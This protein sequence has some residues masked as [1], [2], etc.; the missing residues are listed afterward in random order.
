MRARRPCFWI[1]AATA[2]KSKALGFRDRFRLEDVGHD[3]FIGQRQALRQFVL[4]HV[5]PQSIR[6]RLQDCPQA[7]SRIV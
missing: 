2:A 7:R 3:Y 4:Q 5:T 6:A 1:C